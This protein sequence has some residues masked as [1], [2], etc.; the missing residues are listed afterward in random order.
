MKSWV[1]HQWSTVSINSFVAKI[2]FCLVGYFV[3]SRSA[4]KPKRFYCYSRKILKFPHCVQPEQ[5]NWKSLSFSMSL[6][7]YVKSTLA[8]FRGSKTVS[9]TILEPKSFDFLGITHLKMSKISKNAKFRAVHM[10]KM[11]VFAASKWPKLFSHKIWVAKK[12][13][14]FHIVVYSQL[15][16]PGLY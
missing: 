1:N 5:P 14:H 13:W 4:K 2:G 10:V 3:E 15:G 9:L 16:N 11:A 7:Y 12:S 8:N 6:W